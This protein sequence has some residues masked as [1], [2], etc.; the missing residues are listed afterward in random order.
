MFLKLKT[1]HFLDLI[2]IAIFVCVKPKK[3]V[4]HARC[5]TPLHMDFLI[6][7]TVIQS[8]I[9]VVLSRVRLNT[10]AVIINK[11]TPIY[12]RSSKR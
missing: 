12:K 7:Y 3:N 6:V 9:Y 10:Y 8:Y 2:H 5:C 4:S 11:A 1:L